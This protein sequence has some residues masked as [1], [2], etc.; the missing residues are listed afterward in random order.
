MKNTSKKTNLC[1]K[2]FAK[3][4]LFKTNNPSKSLK[5]NNICYRNYRASW[6]API[7]VTKKRKAL[8]WKSSTK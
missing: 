5:K 2:K 8:I 6:T 7:I 3:S 4:Y 1:G